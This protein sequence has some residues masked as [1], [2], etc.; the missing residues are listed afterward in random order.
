MRAY[1]HLQRGKL[2]ISYA[3]ENSAINVCA[4][5]ACHACLRSADYATGTI[6]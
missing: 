2:S 5:R 6:P 3:S 4:I 1:A